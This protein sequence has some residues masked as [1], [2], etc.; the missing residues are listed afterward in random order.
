M[1]LA[2]SPRC[3]TF[4]CPRGVVF[5]HELPREHTVFAYLLE[6]TAEL[7]VA[8]T[9]AHSGQIA[10]FGPGQVVATRSSTGARLLL[11][12]GRKLGEPVA[13]RG[14]FVMNTQDELEQAYEDYQNGTLV[15]G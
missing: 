10:V 15:S 8:R 2:Y 13:R 4:G 6:G 9:A 14:P 12:A 7:G 11:V 5:E 1:A 3:S